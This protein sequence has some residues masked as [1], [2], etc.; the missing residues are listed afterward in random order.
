MNDSHKTTMFYDESCPIC[1]RE[2]DHYQ[3]IDREKCVRWVDISENEHILQE[4]GLSVSEAM[5]RLHVVDSNGR[6]VQGAWAFAAVWDAL[7]RYHYLAKLLRTLR[8]LPIL[9]RIYAPFARWRYRRQRRE[10][11]C[12]SQ[13][14]QVE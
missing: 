4:H 11:Q 9:D 3:R 6:L 7:P 2:V 8:I 14:T 12:M 5:A 1:R 10:M 13:T